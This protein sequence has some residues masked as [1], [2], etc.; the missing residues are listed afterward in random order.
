MYI[1][2]NLDCCVCLP[3]YADKLLSFRIIEA[4]QDL[5]LS[6]FLEHVCCSDI[7]VSQSLTQYLHTLN[8]AG[9]ID[10]FTVAVSYGIIDV[11]YIENPRDLPVK[12]RYFVV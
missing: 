1:L 5:I 6:L 3:K 12:L 11:E 2:R 9:D 4:L 10:S 8:A 7:F